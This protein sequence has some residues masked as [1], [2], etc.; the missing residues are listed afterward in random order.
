MKTHQHASL[1]LSE[2]QLPVN[3]GNAQMI[4][5]NPV[6]GFLLFACFLCFVL[7]SKA[8][9]SGN[10]TIDPSKSA[11]STNY[12][13]FHSAVCDLDSG[14]R[15]DGGKPN[16]KGVSKPV[17]ITVANGTYNEKV[18]ITDVPGSSTTNTI[19]FTT[20]D[21]TSTKVILENVFNS[22]TSANDYVL[23]IMGASHIRF[24]WMMIMAQ[25]KGGAIK[26]PVSMVLLQHAVNDFKLLHCYIRNNVSAYGTGVYSDLDQN[27][28]D[29]DKGIWDNTFAGTT[30]AIYL[31]TQGGKYLASKDINTIIANNLMDSSSYNFLTAFYQTGITVNNNNLILPYNKSLVGINGIYLHGGLNIKSISNNKLRGAGTGLSLDSC[32]G[33]TSNPG[34]IANNA[35]YGGRYGMLVNY[36]HDLNI[37]FN[38]IYASSPYWDP[39]CVH[40]GGYSQKIN[41]ENN[42]LQVLKI[43]KQRAACIFLDTGASMTKCDYNSYYASDSIG[44]M[45]MNRIQTLKAWQ[46]LTGLD[47]HSISVNPSFDLKN[48]LKTGN[49]ALSGKGTPITSIIADINGSSR[50]KTAPSIGAYEIAPSIKLKAAFTYTVTGQCS[51]SNVQVKLT[52]S[53]YTSDPTDSIKKWTWDFGNSTGSASQNT[54]VI[55]KN[56][57]VYTIKLKI[58]DK[59]G[60]K[61]SSSVTV[62]SKIAPV[63]K[64][65]SPGACVGQTVSFTDLSYDP[66]TKIGSWHWDFGDGNTSSSFAT[67]VT[68]AYKSFGTYKVVI[69]VSNGLGCSA[70]YS[71]PV[72]ILNFPRPYI[73]APAASCGDSIYFKGS[74]STGLSKFMYWS[75]GDGDSSSKKNPVHKYAAIGTYTVTLTG[76]NGSCATTVKQTI[77]IATTVKLSLKYDSIACNGDSLHFYGTD[78]N[79]GKG[80]KYKWSFGDGKTDSLQKTAHK[81]SKAG[82]YTVKLSVVNACSSVISD[83]IK[84]FVDSACVWPGD[85][86]YNKKVSIKD[87]LPIGIAYGKTGLS[88]PNASINWTAQPAYDW[89]KT[90]KAGQNY[91]HADCNGDGVVD[92]TDLKAI[93][94][95]FGKTHPKTDQA[96]GGNPN[97]P[98]LIVKFSKDSA[99]AGDTVIAI[100]NLGSAA[101]HAS[102]IYGITMNIGYKG[103]KVHPKAITSNFSKSWMGTIHKDLIS[104]M[105]DDSNDN[106]IDIGLSRTD[107]NTVSGFGQIGTVSIMM[108]DNI[109]GKRE[110]KQII[111]FEIL[112]YKCINANEDDM[113]LNPLSDSILAYQFKEGVQTNIAEGFGLVIYPNPA[114][115]ILH[116]RMNQA[117]AEKIVI[118]D[119]MGKTVY[120]TLLNK[121][122]D[123]VVETGMLSKG[124]YIISITT[125]KGNVNARF[126]KE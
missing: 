36:S 121:S 11:S 45:V 62:L 50:S 42:S 94:K 60:N 110:V 75:F 106:S 69:T 89:S 30:T 111:K 48:N 9:L 56:S 64:F 122:D 10:Y 112:D 71:A 83:S 43:T 85:A 47:A 101:I 98:P 116:I 88:R 113:P 115:D 21:S 18:T 25:N 109:A 103:Y 22:S 100:I 65:T 76:N 87:F 32:T 67:T 125:S 61:D 27:A 90:F 126:M 99:Q 14:I 26:T 91:K 3:A 95:N 82:Y 120:S 2:N 107:Q 24:A 59:Y 80:L 38:N 96:A 72:S 86:D 15:Y 104:L 53:S 31:N 35:I 58:E 34:I 63:A 102:N 118:T 92:S 16:G 78:L 68:H 93:S 108:P 40:I 44:I 70:S 37:Y 1:S 79:N 7:T 117:K 51:D 41:F 123:T 105:V 66:F 57:A 114:K 77:T 124:M 23:G 84:V 5:K 73:T 12:Q 81:Y 49:T 8:Q 97:D 6:R 28:G 52:D 54:S 55:Y 33:L 39:T 17:T 119:L 29:S 20:T 19:T 13:D 74:D 46:T 4:I